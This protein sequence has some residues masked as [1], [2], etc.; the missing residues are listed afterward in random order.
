MCRRLGGASRQ[1]GRNSRITNVQVAGSDPLPQGGGK[2]SSRAT[3]ALM[4][5]GLREHYGLHVA[6]RTN[7]PRSGPSRSRLAAPRLRQCGILDDARFSG[8]SA[9]DS[10][11]ALYACR[12]APRRQRGKS[13]LGS[14]SA[15]RPWKR[16]REA[17]DYLADAGRTGVRDHR[18]EQRLPL[19]LRLFSL[20]GVAPWISGG[21]RRSCCRGPLPVTVRRHADS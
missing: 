18:A 13:V 15:R 5:F 4:Q 16:K 8:R 2:Y 14:R 17:F 19:P 10:C 12:P 11:S 1:C 9:T 20:A 21:P 6:S 3:T 7:L